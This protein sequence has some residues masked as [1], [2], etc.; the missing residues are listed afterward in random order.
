MSRKVAVGLILT[1]VG[2]AWF[3]AGFFASGPP[4]PRRIGAPLSDMLRTVPFAV[5]SLG[6]R[7]AYYFFPGAAVTSVGLVLLAVAH[8]EGEL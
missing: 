8:W 7:I 6:E 2:V 1:L 5:A 4:P 3:V